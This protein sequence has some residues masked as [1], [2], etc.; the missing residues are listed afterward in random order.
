MNLNGILVYTSPSGLYMKTTAIFKY[1]DALTPL[2]LT[3]GGGSR[4]EPRVTREGEKKRLLARIIRRNHE[5]SRYNHEELQEIDPNTF[6]ASSLQGEAV[7]LINSN[8]LI[9]GTEDYEARKVAVSS[10]T[11]DMKGRIRYLHTTRLD[12]S[13]ISPSDIGWKSAEM[14]EELYARTEGKGYETCSRVSPTPD[15][16]LEVSLG[17]E[18]CTFPGNYEGRSVMKM[19][20]LFIQGEAALEAFKAELSNRMPL[21]EEEK[22]HAEFILL[23]SNFQSLNYHYRDPADQWAWSHDQ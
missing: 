6:Y 9:V 13:R 4:R 17:E 3:S 20:R 1:Y 19:Y 12:T 16:D 11:F 14:M 2:L 5:F 18:K 22:L 23:G 10:Y 15:G 8:V 21:T 7:M